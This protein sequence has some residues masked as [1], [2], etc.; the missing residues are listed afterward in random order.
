MFG[1]IDVWFRGVLGAAVLSYLP[2]VLQVF[3]YWRLEIHGAIILRVM[4]I[5]SQGLLSPDLSVDTRA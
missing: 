2:A 5:W 1:G 4:S 3:D